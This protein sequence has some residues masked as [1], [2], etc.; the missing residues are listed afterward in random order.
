MLVLVVFSP[1]IQD[2]VT[3]GGTNWYRPYFVWLVTILFVGWSIRR[4][5]RKLSA[6]KDREL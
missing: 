2:W 5:Q 1:H 4:N 3:Q 6:N